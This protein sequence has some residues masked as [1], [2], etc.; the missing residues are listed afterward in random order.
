MNFSNYFNHLQLFILIPCITLFLSC[1]T[2][3]RQA[4]EE[5]TTEENDQITETEI[6]ENRV[7]KRDALLKEFD[8]NNDGKLDKTEFYKMTNHYLQQWDSNDDDKL[9]KA[10]LMSDWDYVFAIDF[11]DDWYQQLDANSDGTLSLDEFNKGLFEIW[12]MNDSDMIEPE[13]LDELDS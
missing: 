8:E 11:R 7:V 4:E 6:M 10:E 12:D 1:E 3:T 2:G 5:T 13:E 9:D